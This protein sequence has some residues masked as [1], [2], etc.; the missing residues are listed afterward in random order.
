M[1]YPT[2]VD[3][4]HGKDARI[5]ALEERLRA[6]E[7]LRAT[8]HDLLQKSSRLVVEGSGLVNGLARQNERLWKM[9]ELLMSCLDGTVP[10]HVLEEYQKWLEAEDAQ[11]EDDG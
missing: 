7:Q 1:N 5:R 6:S 4:T 8:A 10:Q 11:E 9:V 3:L 2:R